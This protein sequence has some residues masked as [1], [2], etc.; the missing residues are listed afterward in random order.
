MFTCQRKYV[1]AILQK[2]EMFGCK[3]SLFPMEQN[4]KLVFA[5][6]PPLLDSS[7]YMRLVGRLIYLTI[8]RSELTYSVYILSQFMQT[9]L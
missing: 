4:Y 9:L 6:G 7:R 5:K 8:T 1:L 3:P 2:C